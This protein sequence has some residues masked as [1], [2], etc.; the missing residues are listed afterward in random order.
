MAGRGGLLNRWSIQAR[1]VLLSIT[2]VA[3]V[4]G[5]NL[6]LSRALNRASDAALQ[7]DQLVTLIG[8]TR[9]V[10]DAFA[11]LR[12][13]MTD[14][15]V[16]L[17]TMS[18]RNAA[19]ARQRL[20]DR[21]AAL[22]ERE[23]EVAAKV[24][25]EA[26]AFDDAA[27]KAVDAYTADQRIVG[28]SLVAE[29]RLHGQQVDAELGR[30]EADL[31]VRAQAAR[32][33]VIE[34]SATAR[35]VSLVVVAAAL[36][37]GVLLTVLVLRSILIPL[38]R[39]VTAIEATSRGDLDAPLPPSSEDELGAMTRAMVLFRES[40]RERQRLAAEAD[41]QRLILADAIAS[42]Q[43][44]FV[45]YD[46]ADKLVLQNA[47]YLSLHEGLGAV[48]VPGK[49]FEQV[50]RDAIALGI[51]EGIGHDPEAWI[52]GRLRRRKTQSPAMELR[53]GQR[54]VRM[55]E[56]RT[57]E[58]GI[59]AVYTD[60]T[61]IKQRE[62]ELERARGEAEQANQV[63]SEFLANMS[64]ELRTPL[65]AI[66]GYSQILQEDAEDEGNTSASADL[67]KIESAGNHLLGLINDILDLS[68]VEAGKMEV[69]IETI[70]L[71][72][73]MEDVRLMVQP[74]AAKNGN[75]L[76][77]TCAGDITTMQCDVTKVKQSLLNLLSNASKF[78]KDGR[79]SADVRR[80][81]AVPG[82]IQFVVRDTGIGM[83]EAQRARLFQAFNQADTSTTRK[84]GGTGLGLVITRSFARMLG[85]DVTVQS[86]PNEGSTFTLSLP[87][88]PAQDTIVLAEKT[89]PD[90]EPAGVSLAEALATI[91][92]TD[93]EA[94][95]RR[96]IGAHLAREGY[97]VIYASSGAEAIEV[98]QRDRPDAITLDIMMPQMDG[99]S[100]LQS[101]KAD[102]NLA[103]IPVVLVSMTA[104]R[105]LGFSLG[106]AAVLTK[107]VDRA[108][109]A[110]ALREHCA[111][112]S[113]PSI[114]IVDD[115]PA[116]S[117]LSERTVERMGLRA[118]IANNG[119]EALDWLEANPAPQLIL[120][121][122]LMPVMDGFEFMRHLRERES[123]RRIPVL[124]L[125]AKTLTEAEREALASM[126][127][128]VIAKGQSGHLGL[129]EVLRD[130]LATTARQTA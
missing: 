2:L 116:V 129:T 32:A 81:D 33:L 98:A 43:E 11:G 70:G 108:E 75:A 19:E 110:A 123:W 30:L 106:A 109:L 119:R 29:A 55:T 27:Q 93:D 13:W 24:R 112:V 78:T 65:N 92:V 118:A 54:W 45:L 5:T 82:M 60:I 47:T 66:I 96:I 97:R 50:L 36:V 105:G 26:G 18:E 61:D 14:L 62:V 120:L 8:A 124:V 41:S 104:D 44:G 64:H 56:R 35:E 117:Q 88:A 76:R 63:K 17:L 126:T 113:H 38:R 77:V 94:T 125:T 86:V 40:Q 69:F 48:A 128:R 95:S 127:Q 85:G 28:N 31:A 90:A 72:A 34:R 16:S 51:V 121:D 37:L 79:V 53:F 15:A 103:P 49:T 115:D 23:P 9:E 84:Y 10:H 21:L 80:N 89:P 101:L 22:A 102:P 3:M 57:H 91:L 12:Y 99:W 4:V 39:L 71:P 107:P 59:V 130:T 73:L 6:Y 58:G 1:L 111:A 68:K 52:A 67:N 7:S 25:A 42:I 114:L 87:E 74:L 46:P 20:Q 83:T 122:L 100:V